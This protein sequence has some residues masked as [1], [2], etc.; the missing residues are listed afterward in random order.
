MLNSFNGYTFIFFLGG[1]L[2]L[3][4]KYVVP[5]Y[6]GFFGNRIFKLFKCAL[7]YLIILLK[8][9]FSEALHCAGLNDQ[10]Q[11]LASPRTIQVGVLGVIQL[12]QITCRRRT[13]VMVDTDRRA[14]RS[15]E[16][17]FGTAASS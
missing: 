9:F 10:P 1:R 16:G 5:A 7:I 11:I 13:G 8:L 4:L 17:P 6:Y 12:W 3:V 15:Q 2:V 14:H